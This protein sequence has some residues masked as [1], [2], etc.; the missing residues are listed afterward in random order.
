MNSF[1]W[2]CTGNSSSFNG[3]PA[4]TNGCNLSET[5]SSLTVGSTCGIVATSNPQTVGPLSATESVASNAANSPGTIL[6]SGSGTAIVG[7]NHFQ[8]S[9]PSTATAAQSFSFTVTALDASN[10][11]MSGYSGTVH[12]TSTDA[13][14]ALPANVTLTNGVGT[15]NATLKTLSN[16]T[17]TATDTGNS[18]IAS[19]S[20]SIAVNAARFTVV[21]PSTA[22]PGQQIQVT[23]TA[24]DAL[25][26]PIAS[27]PTMIHFT[28]SDTAATLPTDSGLANG[29]F[30]FGITLNTVGWQTIT[31]TDVTNGVTGT[32]N[33]IADGA[34]H[35][36][37][38]TACR[39][40]PER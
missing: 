23:V 27:D 34:V 20:A 26:T 25:G 4:A 9:V 14:A 17:I 31:V 6:L 16:Q 33:Q 3:S 11:P 10:N 8:I 36:S 13:N 7:A 38:T 21:A 18:F 29:T 19:T 39:L 28:S 40:L 1:V 30:T 24:V 35:R 22:T 32:S 2:N 37:L 15:F 12:F 5:P